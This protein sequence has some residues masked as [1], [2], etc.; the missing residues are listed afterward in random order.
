[1]VIG[2]LILAC[3]VGL[4]ATGDRRLIGPLFGL[5]LLGAF[6]VALRVGRGPFPFPDGG[7]GFPWDHP[8]GPEMGTDPLA[9]VSLLLVT[10][11]TVVLCGFVTA[12]WVLRSRARWR[13]AC[14][15]PDAL[16]DG[17]EEWPG[18]RKMAGA[19]SV[20]LILLICYELA[21]VPSG[22]VVSGRLGALIISG[23]AGLSGAA[24]FSLLGLRW[25]VNLA[26]AAMGLVTL[27]VAALGLT[28][29]PSEPADAA[30]RFPMI[31]NALMMAFAVMTWFWVWIGKVWRQQLDHGR[32]WTAA[33]RMAANSCPRFAFLAACLAL[34]IGWLTAIWP[35]LRPIGV[36]DDSLGRVAASVAAHLT[37][38]LAVLWS[39]RMTG[40]SSFG[41]LAILVVV[42]LV[43][44]VVVRALPLSETVHY[45]V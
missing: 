28:L 25:S 37:L 38:L 3:F 43:G 23:C 6:W 41:V 12:Q 40:R 29:L 20:L 19:V 1:M 35:R 32:A 36:F 31:F 10:G 17:F 21:S 9:G 33:G 26:D 13:A 16:L 42:S 44:V 30:A 5:F 22:G 15:N 11:L 39:G 14:T 18:F 2:V 8:L 24:V 7:Y 34:S 27:G 45:G 4:R